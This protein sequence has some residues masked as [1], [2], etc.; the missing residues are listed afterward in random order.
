MRQLQVIGE[1]LLPWL[2]DNISSS[3]S[4]NP[5]TPSPDVA[6]EEILQFEEAAKRNHTLELWKEV[7]EF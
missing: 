1:G 6:L 4:S 3:G 2:E 5:R 7:F